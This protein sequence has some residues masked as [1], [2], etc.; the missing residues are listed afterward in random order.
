MTGTSPSG[1]LVLYPGPS[2]GS[3]T[4]LQRCSQCILQPQPDLANYSMVSVQLYVIFTVFLSNI[5]FGL[6][7][8]GKFSLVSGIFFATF[9][10]MF[11]LYDG[12]KHIFLFL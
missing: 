1:Y 3:L 2:L 4:P 5:L 11:L 9:V 10:Y 7:E 6:L 12:F 8:F